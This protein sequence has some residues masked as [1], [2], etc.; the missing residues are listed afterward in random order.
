M[1]RQLFITNDKQRQMLS[2]LETVKEQ[3]KVLGKKADE[4]NTYDTASLELLKTIQYQRLTL[5]KE[6]GG[7]GFN[8]YDAIV[9]HE[10]LASFDGAAALTAAWSLITVGELFEYRYWSETALQ[11]FGEKIANGAYTNRAVSEMATGSPTRGGK[12]TS[13]AVKTEE[14]WLLNG[15]KSYTTGAYSL[16]EIL[17]ALHVE[18]RDEMGYFI[19]PK[20]TKGV[21]IEDTWDVLGMRGTGSHDLVLENVHVSD[22]AFIELASDRRHIVTNGWML[23]IPATYLGVSQAAFDE[24]V[25]FAKTHSPNSLNGPISQLPH[26][27]AA[28]GEMAL[29][30]QQAR[31]VL[32]GAA[33]KY[34]EGIERAELVQEIGVVKHTVTNAAVEIVDKAMR[35]VG[36]KSL[37]MSSPLQ[38]YYRNV[39]AGLHNPPMDDMTIAKLA[40][41]ALLGDSE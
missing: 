7:E 17:V 33:A 20:N 6:F 25:R 41:Q 27:R 32:Y 29:Q 2:Q 34:S 35:L 22:E 12:M 10:R 28:I 15:R 39:R 36:A 37:L 14:G 26:I 19:I 21:S 23:L 5:P 24:A 3:L 40:E 8:V 18:E 30:L 31:Y 16:D 9:A 13:T 11:N 38:M 4:T 1:T